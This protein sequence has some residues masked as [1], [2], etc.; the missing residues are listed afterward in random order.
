MIKPAKLTLQKFRELTEHLPEETVIYYHAYYKGCCLQ[1]YCDKDVGF[2][3]KDDLG[4]PKAIVLNPDDDYDPRKPA[5]KKEE[6]V[7]Q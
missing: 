3:L 7:E 2:Y 4:I 5:A 6:N 1:S